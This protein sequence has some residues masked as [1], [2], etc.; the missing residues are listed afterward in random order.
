MDPPIHDRPINGTGPKQQF[1]ERDQQVTGFGGI[2]V[3]H[4]LRNSIQD[5]RTIPVTIGLMTIESTESIRQKP[6][7][8]RQPMRINR[9]V[10]VLA[11]WLATLLPFVYLP[12][13]L[14]GLDSWERLL[15]VL[16][17]LALNAAALVVGH[18]YPDSRPG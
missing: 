11:F 2:P 17:L 3:N 18:D 15:L 16:G 12:V 9:S 6:T 10:T 5:S 8:R 1:T 7:P 4:I 14:T 13:I